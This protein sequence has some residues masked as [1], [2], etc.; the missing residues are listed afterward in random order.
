[1]AVASVAET[2]VVLFEPRVAEDRNAG[3]VMQSVVE[4]QRASSSHEDLRSF[5][6][7]LTTFLGNRGN[8]TKAPEG[9]EIS[10][11]NGVV[12][13]AEDGSEHEGA[14]A[15]K[16]SDSGVRE[17]RLGGSFQPLE[18]VFE[19]LVGAA[20]MMPNEE[21]VVKKQLQ[22]GGKCFGGS[23]GDAE[24]LCSEELEDLPRLN[25]SNL[26]LLNELLNAL[27]AELHRG[28]LRE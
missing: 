16:G 10:E 2:V 23:W 24:W 4:G 1:V 8:A 18:P 12:C 19:V 21:H 7:P 25:S 13:I 14:D 3:P 15:G 5:L 11:S 26:V 28:R 6:A 9:I 20:T 17:G 22:V 27:D